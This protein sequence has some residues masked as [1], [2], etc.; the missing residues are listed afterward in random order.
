[1]NW[2]EFVQIL[3]SKTD[4]TFKPNKTWMAEMYNLMNK[5]LFNGELGQCYFDVFTTGRGSQGGTLGWFKIKGSNIR[6]NRYS[7]RMFKSGWDEIYIDKNNFFDICYPTIELNGNYSGTEKGF[8][9]TLVHEMCHYYTYMYGYAPKQGHGGEFKSIGYE[10]SERSH[11]LFTIQRLAS[12]EDMSQLELSDEMKAK[13]AKRLANKKSTVTAIVVYTKEGQV[14]LTITS[15]PNL[16]NLISKTETNERGNRVLTSNDSEVIDFLFEKGFRKN[17]RSWRY[18]SIEGK[19]WINEFNVL[20]GNECKEVRPTETKEE[21]TPTVN[22][23]KRIFT[24]KTSNGV[25]EYDGTAYFSLFKALKQ[26]FP[27]TS[28]EALKKIINNPANYRMEENKK[29]HK[30]IIKEV[31]DEYMQNQFGADDSVEITPDMNLG[32]YSPLEL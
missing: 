6:I 4:K 26:R 2:N 21:P 9:A 27:F 17:M 23:P 30:S 22:Q 29:N 24:I 8:L 16:I 3:N 15:S 28:D 12:A 20:L 32:E 5:F 25:F 14:K 19:P 13:R 31:I 11:G 18:W 1:M 10:V 7:R